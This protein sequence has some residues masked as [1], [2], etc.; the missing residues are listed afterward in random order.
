M[1]T[2]TNDLVQ[3]YNNIDTESKYIYQRQ[4]HN[5]M[6]QSNKNL[7]SDLYDLIHE[8]PDAYQGELCKMAG[9]TRHILGDNNRV[10]VTYL[11]IMCQQKIIRKIKENGHSYY[12]CIQNKPYKP[13]EKTI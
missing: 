11:D 7:I 8:N 10:L 1:I 3:E 12:R 6:Q 5:R 4:L 13:Y 9:F 2:D